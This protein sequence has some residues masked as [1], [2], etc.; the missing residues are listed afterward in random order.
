VEKLDKDRLTRAAAY[1]DLKSAT[2]DSAKLTSYRTIQIYVDS[3]AEDVRGY[4]DVRADLR[5]SRWMVTANSVFMQGNTARRLLSRSNAPV[6][7]KL[8]LDPKDE[9]VL[10]ALVDI[11]TRKYVGADGQPL[12]VKHRLVRVVDEGNRYMVETRAT[13]FGRRYAFIAPNGYPAY[14]LATTAQRERAFVAANTG[15]MSD[16]SGAYLII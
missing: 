16:G 15:L 11:T 10:G 9:P 1:F 4:G 5:R 8:A 12:P 7:M 14:A 13:A 2:A 3:E 6:K